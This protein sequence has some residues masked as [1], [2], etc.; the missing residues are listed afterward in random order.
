MLK[1]ILKRLAISAVTLLIIVFVLY[2]LL[3]LMPGTPFNDEKLTAE[4]IA[5]IKAKYG[6]D[7]PFLVQ[8]FNYLK[9][10]LQGDFG[11]S[12]AI[13]KN[14]PVSQ[15]LS[16]RFGV[17]VRIGLQAVTLGLII[18]LILGILAALKKNTWID[19][20]ASTVSVMGVSIPSFVFALFFI[21]LFA[22]K[23]NILPVLYNVHKPFV[24]SIMP[25]IALSVSTI[26][27][28]ARFSRGEMAEVLGSEYMQLAKSKG[29]G[30]FHLIF[31]HALRNTM[32]Q[33]VTILAPLVVGLMTGSLVIE[34][35]FSVPGI[36]QLLTM[37]IQVND[38]NV[39]MACTF[40]YS[41]LYIVTML[42]VDILYGIIDPRIR[43]VKGGTNG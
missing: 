41:A 30:K 26:A 33:V 2:L 5:I 18:G 25:T 20:V 32:I 9:M 29:L 36:G 39:I 10:M 3:Q 31:G 42:I 22:R 14:M 4:Q 6:L 35:M 17:S 8:F 38:Y 28:I 7:K 19:T 43:I 24:S 16:A 13:Q 37:G 21:L 1:Y 12:Y 40:I 23:L 27:S 15:I 34:Q 11:V